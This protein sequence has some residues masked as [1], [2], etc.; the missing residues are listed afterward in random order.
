MIEQ[1]YIY[2]NFPRRDGGNIDKAIRILK[3]IKNHG[4]L[5]VPE[6]VEWML[7][8][9]G[10]QPP[11]LFEVTQKRICFT[12]LAPTEVQ[13]HAENFGKF[14]LEFEFDQLRH[15]VALPVTYVPQPVATF[16]GASPAGTALLAG[17]F[18]ANFIL[19]K[20][21]NMHFVT[22]G[23]MQDTE[24]F[25]VKYGFQRD[26]ETTDFVLGIGETKKLLRALGG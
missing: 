26:N 3:S 22:S 19:K 20:L 23:D 16:D 10:R 5:L 13:G 2:H 17:L 6:H 9:E 11:R 8:L 15:L 18:D 21:A 25:T 14:S 12:D 24:S 4:R 1:R 7:P